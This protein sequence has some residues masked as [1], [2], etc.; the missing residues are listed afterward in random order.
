M[1]DQEK[2]LYQKKMEAKLDEWNARINQMKA[3]AQQAD[4]EA[5][6]EIMDRVHALEQQRDS[7]KARL[8]EFK[9]TSGEAWKD[10]QSGLEG[11]FSEMKTAVESAMARFMSPD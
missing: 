8:E 3:K 9:N 6:M 5:R 1:S 2:E 7:F 11:A 10:V 4:V